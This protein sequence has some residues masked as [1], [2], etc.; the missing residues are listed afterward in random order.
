MS[1]I[2]I[3]S[4]L[5]REILVRLPAESLHRFRS[6]CKKWVGIIDD[7]SF[8]KAHALLNSN[9]LYSHTLLLLMK[10]NTYSHRH[11]P[12][13]Y[14]FSLDSLQFMNAPQMIDAKIIS[15]PRLGYLFHYTFCNGLILMHSI[16]D[17]TKYWIIWNPLTSECRR[18]PMPPLIHH[19]I[20]SNVAFGFDCDAD[21]YKVVRI[22]LLVFLETP[23]KFGHRTLVYSL[24]LDSWRKI[25]DCPR[26]IPSCPEPATFFNGTLY[27]LLND[28]FG[29]REDQDL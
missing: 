5:L 1:D 15:P 23:I 13:L 29:E 19:A 3:P 9:Q 28:T 18:I 10:K 4:E 12:L 24:K 7:S 27:W 11:T 16:S 14:S 8:I 26:S 25:E 22:D 17:T 2:N 21:D 20:L 6:V